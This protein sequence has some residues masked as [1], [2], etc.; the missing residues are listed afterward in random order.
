MEQLKPLTTC[1]LTGTT[2]RHKN[3]GTEA[4]IVGSNRDG[5]FVE[6][7]NGNVL[8]LRYEDRGNWDCVEEMNE[9][10]SFPF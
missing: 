3:A 5:F 7:P 6:L 4:K 8:V 1:E 9:L 2:V 10:S